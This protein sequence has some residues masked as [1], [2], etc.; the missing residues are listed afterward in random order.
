MPTNFVENRLTFDVFRFCW[1]SFF[2]FILFFNFI[3]EFDSADLISPRILK[4]L[5]PCWLVFYKPPSITTS[6]HLKEK[7]Y[8]P[9]AHANTIQI[10]VY[11]WKFMRSTPKRKRNTYTGHRYTYKH[12]LT[13]SLFNVLFISFL[14][15]YSKSILFHFTCGTSSMNKTFNDFRAVSNM[16]GFVQISIPKRTEYQ[17][18]LIKHANNVKIEIDPLEIK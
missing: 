18:N 16:F 2:F 15:M 11:S 1:E 13:S 4:F 14:H 8:P 5:F 3:I 10:N 12:T 17:H 6:Q 9:S 7:A